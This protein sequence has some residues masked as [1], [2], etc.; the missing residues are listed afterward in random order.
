MQ[1]ADIL[2]LSKMS[3]PLKAWFSTLLLFDYLKLFQSGKN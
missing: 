1:V 3:W 2:Y